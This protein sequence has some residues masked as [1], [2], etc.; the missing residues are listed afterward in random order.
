M[1]QERRRDGA[2]QGDLNQRCVHIQGSGWKTR[3][4]KQWSCQQ[5]SVWSKMK[6]LDKMPYGHCCISSFFQPNCWW[7]ENCSGSHSML[8]SC[9]FFKSCCSALIS[10]QD[11]H[12]ISSLQLLGITPNLPGFLSLHATTFFFFASRRNIWS[13]CWIIGLKGTLNSCMKCLPLNRPTSHYI[14]RSASLAGEPHQR[15][16][17]EQVHKI[18]HLLS[19]CCGSQLQTHSNCFSKLCQTMIP[20]TKYWCHN[21]TGK[22]CPAQTYCSLSAKSLL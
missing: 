5:A 14:C 7:K 3:A 6:S 18:H 2:Q 19:T 4:P 13:Q 20:S 16:S 8:S 21:C 17:T 15:H 11:S 10:T 22:M 9:T 1:Q 12:G